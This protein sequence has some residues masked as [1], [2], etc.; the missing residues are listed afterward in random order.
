M[1]KKFLKIVQI[2]HSLRGKDKIVLHSELMTS[3]FKIPKRNKQNAHQK[4]NGL[5][6]CD[7]VFQQT[8][9]QTDTHLIY[10][11][12]WVNLKSILGL[13]WWRSG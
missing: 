3:L 8:T 7:T 2:S 1:N 5:I 4:K 9:T 10:I 12:T 11:T 6:N 13:P